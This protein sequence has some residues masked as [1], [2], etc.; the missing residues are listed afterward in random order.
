MKKGQIKEPDTADEF[1]DR[2][3]DS[4]E[5]G[6]RWFSSDL[7]KSLRFYYRAHQDYLN[8]LRLN[9]VNADALYNLPRL[10]FEVYTKY[11]KDDSV[12]LDD[13]E[14]CADALN[15]NKAGGLFQDIPSLCRSFEA[16][17]QTLQ[18][19]G[20]DSL[21]GMDFYYNTAMC[22]Y[23]YIDT[24]CADT[25]NIE[26]LSSETEVV[27]AIERCI[28]FFSKY[29]FSIRSVISGENEKDDDLQTD[30]ESAANACIE[31]YRMIATVYE[32]IFSQQLIDT[33]SL[34]TDGFILQVDSFAE[35][36]SHAG[37]G[38]TLLQSLKI[39]KLSERSSRILE[40]E[41]LTQAWR[42]E[43]SLNSLLE[44][45]L[46]E[47]SSTRSFIDKFE[48]VGLTINADVKW[49]IL[50]ALSIQYRKIT[51]ALR[52]DM[53][54][55]EKSQVLE[56]DIISTK[57]CLLCS[58]F[59]ERADID[60]ERSLLDTEVARESQEVLQNNSRNLL[61]NALIYSKK[62]GGIRESIGGKL[63]RKKRQREA[64][65]R[66]CLLEGKTQED[67]NQI[68][69]ERYWPQEL[70]IIGELE[71]YKRYFS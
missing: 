8:A 48:T 69:G 44:K 9:P 10:E 30:L 56:S 31:S 67:W 54:E 35:E 4:E 50:N 68:V 47:A 29:F 55:A 33:M 65:M 52:E 59:I 11:I 63:T 23:E 28:M 66:L 43:E 41:S 3:V 24:L 17:I 26:S 15:D 14:N 36:L 49:A 57:I 18:Q 37:I 61:R 12:I 62:S 71:T 19:S 40:F 64:A 25:Q 39:A 58:V 5:S 20:N 16:S 70:Q 6:D 60:L 42:S 45:Q 32:T 22:Y 51:E 2:G 53:A 46:I 21:I 1:Y 34:V 13:L 38:E 7:A 27:K